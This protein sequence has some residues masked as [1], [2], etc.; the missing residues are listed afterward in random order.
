MANLI[1]KRG[2]HAGLSNLAV[3][4]GQLIFVKDTNSIYADIGEQRIKFSDVVQVATSSAL[5]AT[6]DAGKI[7]I[8]EDINALAFWNG[9]G[10]IQLNVDTG[11]T[12]VEV[13]GEGNA[14]TGASYD[15]TTRKITFTKGATY[16]TAADVDG[17]IITAV[18]T[19]GNDKDGNAYA[20]VKAYVDA[21]TSGIA[22]DAALGELQ[23]KVDA[24]E[25]AIE[26]I[27]TSLADGG[28]TE[29]AIAAA[30]KAADDAQAHSE[31]VAADL[32]EY[33]EAN[34]AAL[35]GVKETAEQGVADAGT[36]QARA[37]EAYDLADGKATMDEVNA[38]IADAGHAVKTDVDTAFANMETA[39]KQADTDLKTELEGKITEVQTAVDTEKSRA[40]GIEAGLRSDINTV[41][42]DY[43]KAADKTE[44]SNAIAAET[45]RATGIEG[46]LD[47][48]IKAVEDDYL[49][50]A[51][52]TELQGNIDTVAGAVERLTNG[53]SAEEV[54]GVNDLIQY[55]KD[56]GGL[57]F[58][59]RNLDA[60]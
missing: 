53:V 36:A 18:G 24:A 4:D 37:D 2:S 5:P 9:T 26:A 42:N 33:E 12:A 14:V 6:G 50:A 46:G 30:Q 22:T 32:A 55:V 17:K 25:D 8:V 35:A 39:Y 13:T 43:L 10:W 20:N 59:F 29:K 21:K 7:C 23:A 54:D 47:A 48:R 51:D 27:E 11:A 3:Q 28:V 57:Y 31:G 15:A 19:L 16:T 52:K 1:L 44:L 56:H 60:D 34:D 40:E 49:K 41:K 45:E 58:S 38:A